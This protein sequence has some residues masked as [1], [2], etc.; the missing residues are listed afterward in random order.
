MEINQANLLRT[1]VRN[2]LLKIKTAGTCN[3]APS[4]GGESNPNG[5]VK[6]SNLSISSRMVDREHTIVRNKAIKRNKKKYPFVIN[7]NGTIDY[8]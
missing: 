7:I 8:I 6:I 2:A 3:L 4:G 1:L 5:T